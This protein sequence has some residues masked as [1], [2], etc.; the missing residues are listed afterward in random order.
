MHM[1]TWGR[2]SGY[3]NLGND[4]QALKDYKNAIA[5]NP[6]DY[7]TYQDRGAIYKSQ[8]Q[9][10]KAIEDYT[11]AIAVN[12][13]D[14]DAYLNRG[15]V[16]YGMG[17][18]QVFERAKVDRYNPNKIQSFDTAIL[19]YNKAIAINQSRYNAYAARG[20]AYILK[21][22]PDKAMTDFEKAMS[23]TP[24][25]DTKA[26]RAIYKDRGILYM[27]QGNVEKA[28]SDFQKSCNMGD[29]IACEQLENFNKK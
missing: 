21:G 1:P 13:N 12:P 20:L 2:G 14:Y 19:D 24:K 17:M 9:Y 28:K 7:K 29:K 3:F 15:L 25:D 4:Q 10:S 26:W 6:N 5:I 27:I 23:V 11:M 18:E 22:Q 16:Y 8:K